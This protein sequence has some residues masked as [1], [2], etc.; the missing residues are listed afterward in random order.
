MLDFGYCLPIF[1]GGNDRMAR[2]PMVNSLNPKTLEHIVKEIDK[3]DFNSIWVADHLNMNH[4]TPILEG[5][6]TLSW[7]S[8][9]SKRLRLGHIHYNNL[10]RNPSLTAKMYSTLDV[11]TKGRMNF[12]I[13]QLFQPRATDLR[14]VF[15]QKNIKTFFARSF[16]YLKLIMLHG[17]PMSNVS[18]SFHSQSRSRTLTARIK[19]F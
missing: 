3:M 10:L 1:P 17:F 19:C 7:A 8:N 13:D 4:E 14:Q 12:F 9:I 18:N 5:L 16:V 6:T 11:I 15:R 2:T